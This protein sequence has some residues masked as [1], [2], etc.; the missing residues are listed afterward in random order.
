MLV[1]DVAG[2]VGLRAELP[3]GL[4]LGELLGL[5][6]RLVAALLALLA[7]ERVLRLVPESS[8]IHA[9]PPLR[10]F[11]QERNYPVQD[12]PEPGTGTAGRSA[13]R[14]RASSSAAMASL[15]RSQRPVS[16]VL[17]GSRRL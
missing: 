8:E 7:V 13:N 4:V 3:A 17:S 9:V 6:E 15:L 1:G 11:G 12:G 14:R 2:L 5:V 16:V 10:R